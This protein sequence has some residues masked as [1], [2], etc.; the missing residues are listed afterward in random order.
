VIPTRPFQPIARRTAITIIIVTDSDNLV[1][2]YFTAASFTSR[3]FLIVARFAQ[4]FIVVAAYDIVR[5]Y[6]AIAVIAAR[7]FLVIA[8]L[9]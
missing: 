9:A 2:G 8:R 6:L 1:Q 5:C 3:V 4:T 7:V